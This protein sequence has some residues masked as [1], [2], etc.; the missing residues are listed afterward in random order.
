[1]EFCAALAVLSGLGVAGAWNGWLDVLNCAAP[2]LLI[3][4][5]GSVWAARVALDRGAV[6]TACITAALLSAL[7]NLYLLAPDLL[8]LVT[9]GGAKAGVPYRIVTAN[10]YDENVGPFHATIDVLW[11]GA[12]AVLL[13]ETDGTAA[14]ARGVLAHD[15]A[16]VTHCPGAGV[17][18]WIKTPI[19]AQ[20]C[21]LT[22]PPDARPNWGRDFVWLT[23]LGPD[24]QPIT[25]ATTHLGRP[26][27]PARQIMEREA[28]GKALARL[29]GKALIV[30]G[31]FNTTPWTFAM[32]RQDRDLRPLRRQTLF[33]PTWPAQINMLLRPWNMPFMPIDH[34]YTGSRW[35]TTRLTRVRVAGSDHFATQADLVVAR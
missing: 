18:I 34:I 4:A 22:M 35:A 2:L 5:L 14:R 28:L 9:R 25:L 19:L 6:R 12:D 30:A 8:A 21:G 27:P 29:P 13:Q 32:R 20:G 11:R 16:Y 24:R 3:V 17:Q 7:F 10:M 33:W 31:D 26:Y 23:T 1:M 15:Y